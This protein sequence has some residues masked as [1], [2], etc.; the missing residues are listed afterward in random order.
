MGD[1]VDDVAFRQPAGSL[2]WLSDLHEKRNQRSDSGS[3][4]S[5]T[6][7]VRTSKPL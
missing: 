3:E 7:F 4:F 1:R 6:M 2:V 5:K